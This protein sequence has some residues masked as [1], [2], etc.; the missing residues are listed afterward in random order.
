M[1]QRG[2]GHHHSV[3]HRTL[4]GGRRHRMLK[5]SVFS[6]A[7]SLR[8]ETRFSRASFSPRKHPQRGPR[9]EQAVLAAWGGRVRNA[10]PPVFH[11]LRPCPRNG[12]SWRA[13]VGRVRKP[14]FSASCQAGRKKK[15]MASIRYTPTNITPSIQFDSPSIATNPTIRTEIVTAATSK[16]VKIRSNGVPKR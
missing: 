5:K 16:G 2:Q 14:A 11:R 3:D 12:A 8:A 7:Q 9:G 10:T 4:T 15:A 13:G 6:P 1:G